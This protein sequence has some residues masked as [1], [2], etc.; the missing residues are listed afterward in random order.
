MMAK[1]TT[2]ATKHTTV[3]PTPPESTSS[4]DLLEEQEE[5]KP[6]KEISKSPVKIR[7]CGVFFSSHLVHRCAQNTN[8]NTEQTVNERQSDSFMA[9]MTPKPRYA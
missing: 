7:W 3:Y 8:L 1:S 5:V 2:E 4:N 6:T 9:Q